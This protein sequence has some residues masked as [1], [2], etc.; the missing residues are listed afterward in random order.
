[1]KFFASLL[2]LAAFAFATTA[3]TTDV[4]RRDLYSPNQGSGYWTYR[5]NEK[6]RGIFGISNSDRQ[7]EQPGQASQG[8][9]GI[10]NSS[11]R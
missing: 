7:T 4:N 10:S 11:Q 2:L 3:C 9:F 8:I 5:L 1:V 6:N